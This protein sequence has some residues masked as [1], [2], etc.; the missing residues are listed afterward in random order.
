M[1]IA[2]RFLAAKLPEFAGLACDGH[3]RSRQGSRG[4]TSSVS[5]AKLS[6]LSGAASR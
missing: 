3:R 1:Q 6:W 4:K 5:I 2:C